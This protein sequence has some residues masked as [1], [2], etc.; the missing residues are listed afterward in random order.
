[1]KIVSPLDRISK[2]RPSAV[3]SDQT[4]SG[5]KTDDNETSRRDSTGAEASENER[6]RKKRIQI[7][8][9]KEVPSNASGGG[10]TNY[11]SPDVQFILEVKRSN[12]KVI[13]FKIYK[14]NIFFFPLFLSD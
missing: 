7:H 1:M 2:Y 11:N 8:T 6:L 14:S 13:E 3:S 10:E 12:K 4:A 5:S 9:L